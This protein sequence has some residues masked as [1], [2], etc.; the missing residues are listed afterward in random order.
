MESTKPALTPDP[1]RQLLRHTLA[2]VAYRGG[3]TLRD[4]PESF[5]HFKVSEKSRTP[6][7]ILAHM[8]DLYDWAL[9]LCKGKHEW[10]NSTPLPWPKEVE[11]FFAAL[12]KFDD[13]LA[14]DQPLGFPVEKLFQGPVADSLTHVGQLAMLRTLAGC[15]MRGENYFKADIVAGRVGSEQSAPKVEFD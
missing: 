8:G 15:K 9:A 13:Y 10:H 2:T 3:K 7:Q 11:R 1:A 12:Q 5:A 6:A 14:S 4:A